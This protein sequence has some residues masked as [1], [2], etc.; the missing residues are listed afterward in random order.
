MDKQSVLLLWLHE[1]VIVY[2]NDPTYHFMMVELWLASLVGPPVFCNDQP[3]IYLPYSHGTIIQVCNK[4]HH[5]YQAVIHK[6]LIYFHTVIIVY[7]ENFAPVLFSPSGSRVSLKLGQLHSLERIIQ[8]NWKVG[9]FETWQI[10]FRSVGGKNKT[11]RF[12][13]YS[14]R[15]E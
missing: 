11:G 3:Y 1:L 7:G 10:R 4:H 2:H 12:I 6:I 13:Q 9:K 5:L 14:M 8:Q 15:P